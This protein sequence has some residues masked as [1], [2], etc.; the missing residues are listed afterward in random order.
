M[1]GTAPNVYRG[2]AG[3]YLLRDDAELGLGLPVGGPRDIPLMITDKTFD[4]RGQLVYPDGIRDGFFGDVVL[5][6]GAPSPVATVPAGLIRLRLLNAS[7]ARPYR[8][9][10]SA[11]QG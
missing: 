5:V 4:D 1:M 7:N 3:F 11:R 8:L 2:L 9:A 6:N 10:R